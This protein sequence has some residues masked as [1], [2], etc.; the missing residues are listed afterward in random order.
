MI[1]RI[2]GFERFMM[3]P[4]KELPSIQTAPRHSAD[5]AD[6]HPPAAMGAWAATQEGIR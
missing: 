1:L 4:P 5:F 3:Q 2:R 6:R